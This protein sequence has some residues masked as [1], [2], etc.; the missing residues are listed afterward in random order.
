MRRY[1]V[2]GNVAWLA[3]PEPT[4]IDEIHDALHKLNLQGL[5]L[6]GATGDPRIGVQSTNP[7]AQ[8]VKQAIDPHRKFGE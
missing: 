8:R 5:I 4:R 3:L 6:I 2:G 1:S 7:F